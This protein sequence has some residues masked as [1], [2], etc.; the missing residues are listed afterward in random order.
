MNEG[1]DTV[2]V[3]AYIE[4]GTRTDR[5]QTWGANS[6]VVKIEYDKTSLM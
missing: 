2:I 4:G 5:E 3:C 6:S 1:S